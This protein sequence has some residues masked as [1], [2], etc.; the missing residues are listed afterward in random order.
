M[1][2]CLV[3]LAALASLPTAHGGEPPFGVFTAEPFVADLWED[4]LPQSAARLG[5]A[6]PLRLA[7]ARGERTSALI[8][9]R[10]NRDLAGI[11]ATAG[12]LSLAGRDI[13]AAGVR[14]RVI[15]LVPRASVYTRVLG[16]RYPQ[17]WSRKAGIVQPDVLVRDEPGFAAMTHGWDGQAP[18][19]RDDA[20]GP[21]VGDPV[22]AGGCKHFLFTV[23]VPDDARP[24]DGEGSVRLRAGGDDVTVPVRLTVHPFRLA[25]AGRLLMISNEFAEPRH[26]EFESSLQLLSGIGATATRVTNLVG[27]GN[28]A[29]AY[30]VLREHGYADLIENRPAAAAAIRG[31]PPGFNVH[32]YG[33]D[34]PQP[35]RGRR[36]REGWHRLAEHVELSRQIHEAG[37]KVVTSLPYTLALELRER[38]SRVYQELAGLGVKDVYQPLDWANYGLG[39]QRVATRHRDE[40]LNQPLFDYIAQLQKG[41][42]EGEW[43]AKGPRLPSKH[44][45]RET[46]YFPTGLLRYPMLARL[47]N[48]FYL[49]NTHLDGVMNWTLYRVR[50]RNPFE[51][52]SMPVASLACPA[53][54]SFYS[55]YTLEAVGEGIDD[56]RYARTAY[57]AIAG[58]L[59]GD[60]GQRARGRKLRARLLTA[61][62]PWETL[63]VDGRRIDL[64]RDEKSLR[65]TREALVG[66]IL[67]AQP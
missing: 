44:P 3:C 48:G 62:A 66:I 56:L 55:T 17:R 60:E 2:R 10:G 30:A 12:R 25:P 13:P 22:K 33:L 35:K 46:Y 59:S 38:N 57:E 65:L 29:R 67:D 8:C 50:G 27:G 14:L 15:R 26:P 49:F 58:L 32:F 24:G 41:F 5:R 61:L 31:I 43:A 9:V 6:S 40:G 34:E 47:L 36:G 23:D 21:S 11:E 42:R 1:L 64:V 18:L 37:G 28:P 52:T 54:G 39:I 7:A 45:W 20:T 53:D 4:E 63:A 19:K 51:P 16:D